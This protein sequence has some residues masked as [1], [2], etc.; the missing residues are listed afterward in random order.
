MSSSVKFNQRRAFIQALTKVGGAVVASAVPYTTVRAGQATLRGFKLA[1]QDNL[2]LYFDLD[3]APAGHKIFI[4][5]NP[6]R[7]V[8]DLMDVKISAKMKVG[9]IHSSVVKNIRYATHDDSKLRIVVDLKRA[10]K[11]SYKF[12]NRSGG[13]KRLIVD[14]GI[15]VARVNGKKVVKSVE[16]KKSTELRDIVVAIDA[17]HGGRD[18][19]AI[20]VNKTREKDVTLAVARRLS[21]ALAKVDGIKPVLIR[22]DDKYISLRER[23]RL[24]RANKADLFVSI[25]ADAFRNKKAK[26]ASVYA[27]SLKG[28]SSEAAQWLADK[29]NSVDLFGDISLD[30]RTKVLRE[31]LFDLAQNATLES[32]LSVGDF[33][34]QEMRRFTSLHKSSVEMANFAVLKSP[35]IP[36]VLVETA[37]LTN[38]DEER[39]LRSSKHQERLASALRNAILGYFERMA[40]PGTIL[41][42]RV[43][44][45]RKQS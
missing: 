3:K 8:I 22:K 45:E 2:E 37:F 15:Q 10:I 41:A 1:S 6:D 33:M 19:G 4:L 12:I 36:S 13:A 40:P 24:A 26:G 31:T 32:S 42:S 17:G 35:D 16:N 11:H 27:L 7:L 14:M 30:G 44:A 5:S 29:E 21:K 43:A 9:G 18:P 39:K 28:A 20:G 25:H 34:L 38:P 23:T